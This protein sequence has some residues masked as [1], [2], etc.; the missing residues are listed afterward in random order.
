MTYSISSIMNSN[1]FGIPVS[2][3]D[4]CGTFGETNNETR[5]LCA[6]WI[7]LASFYPF[8]RQNQDDVYGGD[9][10]EPF[11]FNDTLK[12]WVKNALQ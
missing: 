6:R 9:P 5:E 12:A 8:A 2:G 1:M 10:I 3:P 7:Q 11:T 4:T